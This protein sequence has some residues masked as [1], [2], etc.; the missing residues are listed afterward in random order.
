MESKGKVPMDLDRFFRDQ[1]MDTFVVLPVDKCSAPPGFH[2]CDLLTGAKSLVIFGK[3]VPGGVYRLPS[4][5]KTAQVH[6]IIASLDECASTL[7]GALSNEGFPSVQVPSFFPVRISDGTLKGL[8]SLKHCA[9]QAGMGVIGMNTLLISP[10]FG[11][12]LA[13]GAVVTEKS[14]YPVQAP[15]PLPHC[16]GCRKCIR[17]CP[18]EAL[19]ERGVDVTRCGNVT[20]AVPALFQPLFWWLMRRRLTA[21]LVEFVV[22]RV[23]WDAGMVCSSCLTACPYFKVLKK[24]R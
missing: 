13:L 20:G 4:G 5:D 19:H 12:R 24:Q 15:G 10:L 1:G 6:E 8:I 7:S 14:I 9:E 17:A 3:E 22:N 11:N 23:A 16:H 21:P 2:P 18:T